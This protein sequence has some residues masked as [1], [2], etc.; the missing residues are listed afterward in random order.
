V[1]RADGTTPFARTV[2]LLLRAARQRARGRAEQ[3][4]KLLG[5]KGGSA[6]SQA[7]LT[8]LGYIVIGA[9]HACAAL[10]LYGS[11]DASQRLAAEASGRRAVSVA[12]LTQLERLEREATHEDPARRSSP[13]VIQNA[14]R[15][16]LQKEA[17]D[18]RGDHGVGLFEHYQRHGRA[19]FVARASSW[20]FARTG[21][22]APLVALLGSLLVG[23]WFLTLVLQGE[24]L[25]F[26]LQR[27][28]HPMWEWLLGH[29]VDPRAVFLAEMLAP[30]S[31]NPFL[32]MAPVFWVGLFWIAYDDF[33]L[34][35]AAGLAAGVPI[36]VAAGCATKAIEI[37]SFLK[38]PVRSRGA[39]LGILA[40]IGQASYLLLVF[41]AFGEGILLAI[42]RRLAG[43]AAQAP[44]PL[45]GWSLGL[46][47]ASAWK[48]VLACWLVSLATVAVAA[49]V[50][51]R[52]TRHGLAGGFGSAVDAPRP[53]APSSA[54][55][56]LLRDPLHRKELLW[57]WRDRSALIQVFLVPLTAAGYQLFNFRH[58]LMEAAR[59]WHLMAGASVLLGTYFLMTLGPRSLL[60]EGA[61]LWIPLTW[62]R[63]LDHLLRAKARLWCVVSCVVVL[64]LLL[65]TVLR[66]PAATLQIA[67]VA[68]LWVAF[69]VSLAEKSVTLVTVVR[70]SGE[71]DPVP[72]GRRWAAWLGTFTFAIGVISQR[73]T[74]AFAGVVFS[75]MT[76]AAMWQ[77]LRA[78]LPFLFDP[79]SERLPTPPTVLHGMV[80]L[81]A[82]QEAMAIVTL[83]LVLLVGPDHLWFAITIAYGVAA[84]GV[85]WAFT[86]WLAGRGVRARTIWRWSEAP[87]GRRRLL[88]GLLAA[89]GAG[90]ALGVFGEAYVQ[91]L[92]QLARWGWLPP[93]PAMGVG[94]GRVWLAVVSIGMAPVGEEFL[95]RG[96]LFKSLQREWGVGRAVL[97]SACFFAVYHQPLA[98]I[99]VGLLGAA[100]ALLFRRSGH[101]APSVLL[102]MTYNAVV[103]GM[104]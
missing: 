95:F 82:T 1:S 54:I 89:V 55:F 41:A 3:N 11:V 63:G 49:Q 29:P 61:A 48:G 66:F 85:A 78:R 80:A 5:R 16:V 101:L 13:D 76:A 53:L 103:V 77:N 43:L 86:L 51:A 52:A 91:V 47:S 79:W 62:P 90:L 73:W 102:H 56:R 44:A 99:P 42:A 67:L 100:C 92:E 12:T 30:L 68:V 37:V 25:E 83:I 23:G 34:A 97:G 32:A 6:D 69:A 87:P 64:P 94:T 65:L 31:V 9:V 60:S 28:R 93:V 10:L 96:L 8:F 39:V 84:I 81:S 75:W 27:R 19:G 26:D 4:R 58:M 7:F 57:L 104:R 98:W 70:E 59:G 33:G 21:P 35:L 20:G 24:G 71:I 46:G 17:S 88:G 15:G 40:W 22:P 14:A 2:A 38:L 36:A 50:S 74:L 72:H 18:R 45:L